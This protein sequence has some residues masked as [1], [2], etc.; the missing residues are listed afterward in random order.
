MGVDEVQHLVEELRPLGIKITIIE[1]APSTTGFRDNLDRDSVDI[2]DYD[3]TVREAVKIVEALP[4]EHFNLPEPIAAAIM[5]AVDADEPPVRL[6]TGSAAV[7]TIRNVLQDRL[8]ELEK[9][10]AVSIAVDN[11]PEKLCPL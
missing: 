9:W 1:P 2:A 11:D 4:A 3:Q 6:A 8:A 10:E 7:N 5:T